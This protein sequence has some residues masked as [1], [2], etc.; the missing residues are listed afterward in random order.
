MGKYFIQPTNE[1]Q[2]LNYVE[3]VYGTFKNIQKRA[4]RMQNSLQDVLSQGKIS[5]QILDSR[6]KLKR[7][8]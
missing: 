6:G 1:G 8:V 2:E 5:V 3:T 4:I 7:V